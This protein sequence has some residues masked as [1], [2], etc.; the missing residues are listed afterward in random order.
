MTSAVRERRGA[1]VE[2]RTEL[3]DILLAG[4]PEQERRQTVQSMHRATIE[5]LTHLR[6]LQ[7]RGE[8]QDLSP[9]YLDLT[10]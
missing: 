3:Q 4:L 8:D 6:S 1:D 2:H 7:D 9:E 5:K 10:E